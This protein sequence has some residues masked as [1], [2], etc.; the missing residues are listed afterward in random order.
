MSATQN[1]T[2][3]T[4]T[5]RDY[6]R[7]ALAFF[8]SLAVIAIYQQ[9]RL[10]IS[11][12]LDQ[13]VGKS[14][15][16]L[17]VH[18]IGFAALVSLPMAFIFRAL[19]SKRPSLGFNVTR[20]LFL[21][22]LVT[23]VILVEYYVSHFEILGEGF[24][25]VYGAR[26]TMAEL[27]ITLL[28]AIPLCTAVFYLFN[29]LCSS[30]YQLIGRMYPFTII[31]FSLF[32][33]TLYS[34]KKPINEN[35]T[36][37]LVVNA[38]AY[39]LDLNKY[40]GDEPYPLLKPLKADNDLNKHI[41]LKEVPPNIVLII[42]DGVGSDFV[43]EEA[44]YGGFMPFLDSLKSESVYWSNHLSNTGE[45]H[46]S[47]PTI[48]GSL[49]FGETGFN[50][51][52]KRINRNTLLGILK[53]N[54]YT[55]AFN[56]GG[57][58]AL[59][60]WDKFLFEDRVSRLLDFKGFGASYTMQKE[61]A[62]GI[63]LGYPDKELYRKWREDRQDFNT[64]FVDVF[65]TLSSKKPFEIPNRESYIESVEQNIEENPRNRASEK[66][67]RKNKE[68]F[69]SLLYTD[70]ALAGFIDKF[71]KL[72]AYKNTIFIIT[73]SHNLTELP[74]LDPLSRYRV[75]LMI[76]SPLVKNPVELRNLV[77]HADIAP[78][79][80]GLLGQS[81]GLDLPAQ[82][83]FI[84]QGLGTGDSKSP[85][86]GIPLYR[87]AFGIKDYIRSPYLLA[88]GNIYRIGDDLSIE[89]ADRNAPR[90]QILKEHKQFK[91]IN[92]YVVREDKLI[93][94]QHTLFA[95]LSSEPNKQEMIWINS[96]FNGADYDNAYKT[97][98]S[99]AID[100]H[101]ERALLLSSYILNKVPGHADTE[102]LM[103]RIHAWQGNYT[104]SIEILEGCIVKYPVYA[105]G[106]SALLD[107][108]FWSGKND[109]SLML[110]RQIE[111]NNVE[112]E[113]LRS[114]MIRAKKALIK[115]SEAEENKPAIDRSS[116]SNNKPTGI[117]E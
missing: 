7:M 37:H 104:T 30:T 87:H 64:P 14:L 41:A 16:L 107:V 4:R 103:G 32:L 56:Y 24:L 116:L 34:D 92:K 58:S 98:R 111:R 77:S 25:M 27:V 19:E 96:V 39:A 15:F 99:L 12:V 101:Y 43:G 110:G 40:E 59:V 102:I 66:I 106:Y 50:K 6:T 22:L 97:A 26:T 17:F 84:G 65:F 73:G 9:A 89:D 31:L 76:H 61:D 36:Q 62:A 18:H 105:D 75:P 29:R 48:L 5:L 33:A 42:L 8:L 38:T 69:A 80:L 49:P 67:I 113:N 53:K 52:E 54:G 88:D 44:V 81:Y 70:E 94:P 86:K 95:Q 23:E 20:I 46:A 93:P 71:K 51:T 11:G 68:V 2:K 109:R 3:K 21:G 13:V 47:L 79:L 117:S 91:A 35:K 10:Y 60:Q 82:T 90:S 72:E 114:K 57:N 100:G 108:Y 45:G 55:A 63:S 1:I 74:P 28:I 85:G 112:N 115:S 78:S 83:S